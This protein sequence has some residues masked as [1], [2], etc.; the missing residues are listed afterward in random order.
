[1][2][3]QRVLRMRSV[4]ARQASIAGSVRAILKAD[5]EPIARRAFFSRPSRGP[6]TPAASP[7]INLGFLVESDRIRGAELPAEIELVSRD[8]PRVGDRVPL[9]ACGDPTINVRML[10]QESD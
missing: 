7:V 10:L 3:R 4:R 5:G 9:Y 2:A 1:M 8:D 6:A